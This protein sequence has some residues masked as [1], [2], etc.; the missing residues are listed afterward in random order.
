MAPPPWLQTHSDQE[1]LPATKRPSRDTANRHAITPSRHHASDYAFHEAGPGSAEPSYRAA[2]GGVACGTNALTHSRTHDVLTTGVRTN[3]KQPVNTEADTP[4]HVRQPH[5]P[6][7][8]WKGDAKRRCNSQADLRKQNRKAKQKLMQVKMMK[9]GIY[10]RDS[11]QMIQ[12][13][14]DGVP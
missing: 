1:A 2:D 4:T 12:L 7:A 3:N 11:S 9:A 14:R 10:C 8:P 6:R 13:P 5:R